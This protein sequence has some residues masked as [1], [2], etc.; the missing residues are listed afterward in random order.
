MSRRERN[1]VQVAAVLGAVGAVAYPGVL[2]LLA[3][4]VIGAAIGWWG[5]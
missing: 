4:I 2:G 1:A 3:G 5:A